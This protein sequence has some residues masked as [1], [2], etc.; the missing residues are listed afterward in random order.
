MINPCLDCG[1]C[2]AFFRASF[3]WAESDLASAGG[4][5]AELTEKL[6]DFRLVM[7]GTN[8]PAP[9]C[10]ALQGKI[11]ESVSCAIYERRASVCRDFQPAW[12]HGEPNERCDRAR[13]QWGIAPLTPETWLLPDDFPKA[14]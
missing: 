3:Y 8:G 4:V 14:A 1:A 11:G 13:K 5:P 2:C 9:Y 7:Q 10:V 12:L 6:N